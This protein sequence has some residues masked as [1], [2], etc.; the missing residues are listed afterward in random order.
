LPRFFS[1]PVPGIEVIPDTNAQLTRLKEVSFDPERSVIFS[2]VPA[3]VRATSSQPAA[4]NARV[5]VLEKEMNEYR[6]RV[7]SSE[8][9]V[10]VASQMFYPGWKAT[11][12]GAQIPVYPVNVALTGVIVP[13]GEHDVRLFFQPASFRIGFLISL[14]STAVACVPIFR[15]RH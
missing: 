3:D 5:Q 12:D 11:V 10:V 9:A 15:R 6:L 8:P 13:G 14:V 1:V 4:F 2:E 7:K